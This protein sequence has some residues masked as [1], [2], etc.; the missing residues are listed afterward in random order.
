MS[1]RVNFWNYL[2]NLTNNSEVIPPLEFAP[3]PKPVG[4]DTDWTSVTN[5]PRSPEM[6]CPICLS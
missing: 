1:Q 6:L 4:T 2:K 3:L 5:C